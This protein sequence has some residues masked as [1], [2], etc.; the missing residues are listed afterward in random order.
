VFVQMWIGTDDKLP[1]RSRA[2]FRKDPLRLR[3]QVEFS[4]W[5]LGKPV[6][7]SAFAPTGAVAARRIPFAHPDPGPPGEA[8]PAASP[9]SQ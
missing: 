8:P 1:R 6:A 9:K 4:N 5:Q 7:A 2:V 3:H